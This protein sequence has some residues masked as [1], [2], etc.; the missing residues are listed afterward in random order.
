MTIIDIADPQ[1]DSLLGSI[2][3]SVGSPQAY[4]GE[5]R[6]QGLD[7]VHTFEFSTD[8]R[9]KEA[10]LIQ[11]LSRIIIPA[12]RGGFYEFV[13]YEIEN[14]SDGEMR[15]TCVG[16]ET[17]MDVLRIVDA[18]RWENFTPTQFLN[19]AIAGTGWQVGEIETT[20]SKTYSITENATAFTFLRSI[21]NLYGMELH[22]RLDIRDNR[23]IGRYVDLLQKLGRDDK[24]EI[25]AGENMVHLSRKVNNREI[26]T[27]LR[28]YGPEREDGTRLDILVTDTEAFQRW[29][30]K[31]QHRIKEYSPETED[32]NMTAQRLEVL[33][34]TELNKRINS[35]VE[36]EVDAVLLPDTSLGDTVRIKDES[37]SP[38]LYAE[39]R[40]IALSEGL[41][42]DDH[43]SRTY[44][45]GEIKELK[46]EDVMKDFLYLQQQFGALN[47]RGDTPPERKINVEWTDTSGTLDIGKTWNPITQMWEKKSPTDAWE[48]NAVD[49]TDY[50]G[51]RLVELFNEP[52]VIGRIAAERIQLVGAVDVL[53]DISGNLGTMNVGTINL[54]QMSGLDEKIVFGPDRDNP[55]GRIDYADD[56]MRFQSDSS[57]YVKVN[58]GGSN[59][60]SAPNVSAGA[61][62]QLYGSGAPMFNFGFLEQEFKHRTIS[63]GNCRLKFLNGALTALQV[64]NTADTALVPIHA[65]ELVTQSVRE[66]KRN[67]TSYEKNATHEIMTTPVRTYQFND[68]TENDLPRIGLIYDEAPADTVSVSGFGIDVYS[69]ASMLWKGFQ[70]QQEEISTLKEQMAQMQQAINELKGG[71]NS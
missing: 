10:A 22:F 42:E 15:V 48:I 52:G 33:G 28:C 6:Q 39:S 38:P 59:G 62:I 17:E 9:S 41:S 8:G 23:I 69:M 13:A 25:T 27:A 47:Y 26:L 70:E 34:R 68:D 4:W 49:I 44:S 53:S 56:S 65:S 35:I 19:L 36:Y 58:R 50:N 64:R 32:E 31:G 12:K 55:D 3:N 2:E 14:D 37:F 61:I 11:D 40:V 29:N 57:T 71:S 60:F 43:E 7:G 51:S 63:A 21:A 5:V 45:I 67:I 18:N 16:S 30:W 54:L 66:L 1:T 20:L 24:Q 46:K